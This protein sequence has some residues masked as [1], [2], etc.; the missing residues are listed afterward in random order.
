MVF[1]VFSKNFFLVL[2]TAVF[3]FFYFFPLGLEPQAQAVVAVTAL[4]LVLWI[5]E[6]IPLHATALLAAFLLVIAGG[7]SPERVFAQF[8]D[9]V[10]VLVLGGFVLAVALSKHHLDEFLAHKILGRFSGSAGKLLF[11][12]I[13]VTA[14]LSMWMSNSAAAAIA[15]PIA[16]VI[17]ANNGL[18]PLESKFGKAMVLGVAY[19]ATIGGIGTLIG[20][21]PNV[22]TQKFLTQNGLNFGF[23]EWGVR[24]FPFMAA[25]VVICWLVLKTVF[26]AEV[27][28]VE[29]GRHTHAFSREQKMVAGVFLL[30]VFLW[31]TESIHGIHNSIVALVPIILLYALDLVDTKDFQ[32]IG[33]DSLILIGGGIALGMAI[34]ESGL[35]GLLSSFLGGTL[36][37]QPLVVILFLLGVAGIMLTSFLSNTAA[38]A[39]L[40]PIVTSLSVVLGLDM[41]NLVVAGAIGVSLDFMF[42]MGTPPSA[43]AYSSGY[44][45]SWDMVKAGFI[46]SLVGA[47]VLTFMGF[48]FWGF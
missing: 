24:G 47:L 26:R 11:G 13:A 32:K 41:T 20:S 21:T 15:M 8:F 12:V 43:L 1:G 2:G 46:I 10:V 33:W 17:L 25:M 14:F 29:I 3:L 40:I 5:S 34:E 23:V 31:V 7:F 6:A 37:N 44:I 22:L 48:V 30:T 45:H 36:S 42:P 4:A 19:G 18:K 39:V 9:R 27:K 38:S 16:L 28:T 35:S